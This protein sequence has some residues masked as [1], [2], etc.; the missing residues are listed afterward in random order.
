[1][2]VGVAVG[3]DVGVAVNVAVAVGVKVGVAVGVGV[4]ASSQAKPEPKQLV[5]AIS[6]STA[7]EKTTKNAPATGDLRGL[8]P[9]SASSSGGWLI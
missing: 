5:T 6:A 3:V 2:R 4:G 8:P 9:L 7:L 1:M